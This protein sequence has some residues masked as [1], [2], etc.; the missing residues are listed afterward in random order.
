MAGFRPRFF[1]SEGQYAASLAGDVPPGDLSGRKVL[2]SAA[3][4]HH[5]TRAL[6]LGP[7]DECEVVVGAAVYAATVVP[8][9]DP[10]AVRLTR[11]LEGAEAGAVYHLQVGVAQALARPALVDQVL[12]KGT[13]AGA[14]FFVL[15]PADGSPRR[16]EKPGTDRVGRW[17]RIVQE[18]AKQSKQVVVPDVQTAGS[19]ADALSTLEDRETLSLFLDPAAPITLWER[20]EPARHAG[21]GVA[22]W[23][24]PEGGWSAAERALFT[25]R[26]VEGVRLGRG[27]L[28][29]E[30]AGP[31]S[32]AVA[33]LVLGDW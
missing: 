25:E 27:V 31:V 11:R 1:V 17:C 14:S 26:G 23:V 19:L 2:L 4:S 10:V 29:T 18:A 22:L 3:D 8:G 9:G 30:T 6:R 5:A 24:G 15:F 32:V 28:R 16:G 13:E 33:R 12:E 7:G 21:A 20:L